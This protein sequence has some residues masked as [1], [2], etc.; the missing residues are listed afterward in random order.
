MLMEDG[1]FA[2]RPDAVATDAPDVATLIVVLGMHRGGTSVVVRAMETMGARLGDRL[3]A[4]VAGENDKGFFEDLDIVS[5]NEAV[6]A[7]AGSSW[8]TLAP[9]ELGKI[10]ATRL[11]A[12]RAEALELL[13]N[14][15]ANGIFA[16]K[17][18]RLSRL[19]PFW[20]SVFNQLY[21]NVAYVI[22]LRNPTSVMRSLHRRDSFSPEK[23]YPLWLAHMVPAL[24]ATQGKLRVLI[25]YDRLLDA[26]RSELARI[27]A[28]LGLV[29]DVERARAFESEFLDRSLRHWRFDARDIERAHSVPH[30]IGTLFNVLR[31]VGRPGY[32]S[33]QARLETALADAEAYLDAIV[34]AACVQR[35][36]HTRL[37]ASLIGR[38]AAVRRAWRRRVNAG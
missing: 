38:M 25:E 15:C 31:L 27:A 36:G 16:L 8:H 14:K 11:N 12:L 29:L 18:P 20:Q 4:P 9:I 3:G 34:P 6:L 37:I 1:L 26:P 28:H 22:A 10:D 32:E 19:L 21:V 13:R 17:D 7:A 23:A 30:Q 2:C 33:Q 35:N 5:L 24:R